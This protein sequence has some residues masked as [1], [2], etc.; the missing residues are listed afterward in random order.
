MVLA[1]PH[2]ALQLR[3]I[4]WAG[5]GCTSWWGHW[6][7]S[8]SLCSVRIHWIIVISLQLHRQS[9]LPS[10]LDKMLTDQLESCWKHSGLSSRGVTLSCRTF[11]ARS[12][13]GLEAWADEHVGNLSVSYT[14][15]T[16]AV[17]SG[18]VERQRV[19]TLRHWVTFYS[20]AFRLKILICL[21]PS[22][23]GTVLIIHVPRVLICFDR[24]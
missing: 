8:V 2:M 22:F 5:G 7:W 12:G 21:G 19:W 11:G 4:H 20:G 18:D 14:V 10:C 3:R 15:K 17:P 13:P 16:P 24:T 9:Q 6:I 23:P 1:C